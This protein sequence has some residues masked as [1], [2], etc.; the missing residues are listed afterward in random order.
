M[1]ERD[2][3]DAWGKRRYPTGADDPAGQI[4]S[5]TTTRG[6][7]GQEELDFGLVHL[8]GRV[9]DPLVGRM[10]SADPYVP[11]P[12]NGQAWNRYAYV[13]NNPLAFTDPSGYCFLG[14]CTWGHAIST[15][16]DRSF[17]VLF[18]DVP[19]LGTL[20]E[21][22]ATALCLGNPVCA[23]PVAFAST[24]FVADVTSGNLGYALRAGLIA[25]ATAVAF[26]EVG[27]VTGHN[28]EFGTS[29]YFENVAGHALVGC[30]LAVASG[31]KCGPAA[32]AGGITSAA[33]PF[34]TGQN[35]AANV[36]SNAVLGG[37]ASVAGGGKFA[38]GAITGAFGYLLN[39]CGKG[40]CWT[41]GEERSILANGDFLGYYSKACEGGDGYACFSYGVASGEYP[42]PGVTL[43]R[44]LENVGYGIEQA[45]YLVQKIIPLDLANAYANYLPQS[46]SDAR[47]PVAGDI[48]QFHWDE[49]GTFGLP[50]STFGGTPF[51]ALGPIVLKG[52]WCPI[53]K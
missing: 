35:F 9:Y 13:I 40:G 12:L 32:L 33:G 46:E 22:G 18:R 1:V 38:N 39:A 16:F 5:Q 42:G 21:I 11:D 24:A 30:A 49:F 36:G 15:F 43:E 41:T 45:Y 7:T 26:Y 6:F 17:G 2:G 4:T 47:F 29:Q 48:A 27:E 53:C 37:L 3:Y 31:G 8:N 28:P 20:F 10:M 19:I 34:I 23:I 14:M 25:A 50:P 52:L 44:A 51:G